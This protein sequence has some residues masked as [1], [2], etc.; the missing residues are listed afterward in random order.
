M[1][2]TLG[3]LAVGNGESAGSYN[4]NGGF[5]KFAS[6]TYTLDLTNYG[7]LEPAE[8]VYIFLSK[9]KYNAYMTTHPNAW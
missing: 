6:G 3:A 4:E 8:S 2:P 1:H 5:V 7:T 9:E